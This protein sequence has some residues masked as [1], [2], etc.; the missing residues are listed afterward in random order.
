MT[1]QGHHASD[2][3]VGAWIVR[4]SLS[5]IERDDLVVHVTPRAMSVLVYLGSA[6]GAV[7]SRNELLDNVWP[8]MTVT[9][10]ALSQ[11]IVE[12]RRAF[13]DDCRRPHI[14]E[15]IPR[16][17]LRLI[18]PVTSLSAAPPVQAAPFVAA[19]APQ[20]RPWAAALGFA[21]IVIAAALLSS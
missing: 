3:S 1:G 13:G 6:N 5:R 14:I 16:I 18:A 4:P 7:V 10:D 21:V 9:S 8:R 20:W 19:N 2:F 17:G 11:C 12:L 15:T